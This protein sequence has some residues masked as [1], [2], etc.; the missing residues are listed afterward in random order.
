MHTGT[1]VSRHRCGVAVKTLY[2][3][4]LYRHHRQHF[5]QI[6][7]L[8]MEWQRDQS[9]LKLATI[10]R[11]LGLTPPEDE[12]DEQLL[13]IADET[14]KAAEKLSGAQGPSSSSSS[15]KR[16]QRSRDAE[17]IQSIVQTF[18]ASEQKPEDISIALDQLRRAMDMGD[19]P[20]SMIGE[21]R[22]IVDQLKQIASN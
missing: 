21:A 6:H 20:N 9:E 17:Y 12:F 7:K 2:I 5:E 11:K 14:G 3:V 16:E 13:R 10:H 15:S 1:S 8:L 4:A 22:T 19:I 18:N